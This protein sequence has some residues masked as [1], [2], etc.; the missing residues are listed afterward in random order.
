MGTAEA[1]KVH[2]PRRALVFGDD[3]CFLPDARA[4]AKTVAELLRNAGVEVVEY[5]K[6]HPLTTVRLREEAARCDLLHLATHAEFNTA[7][8]WQ[9]FIRLSC[10]DSKAAPEVL[11]LE[12]LLGFEAAP[13]EV[14]LSA[15][16]TVAMDRA[17][18]FDTFSL[19]HGFL[20]AG[21]SVMV[22]TL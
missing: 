16:S 5:G 7:S 2:R 13:R 14:V 20:H 8:S 3:G 10:A 21:S 12:A 11:S 17:G 4:E 18:F 6:D 22:G 15:C 19:A 1:S 9:S